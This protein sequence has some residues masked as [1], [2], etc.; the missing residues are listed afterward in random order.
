MLI[1][2]DIMEFQ[3]TF[4]K[5]CFDLLL[6]KFRHKRMLK[7]TES[8]NIYAVKKCLKK[9]FNKFNLKEI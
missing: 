1:N 9:L 7:K 6:I 3:T 2:L 4:V 5:K 8:R